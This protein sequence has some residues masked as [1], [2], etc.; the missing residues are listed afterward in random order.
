MEYLG[1]LLKALDLDLALT[2]YVVIGLF[3][4]ALT[5]RWERANPRVHRFL[6]ADLFIFTAIALFATNLAYSFY[7][8]E[9]DPL[10]SIAHPGIR[11]AYEILGI[12]GFDLHCANSM[13]PSWRVSRR[14]LVVLGFNTLFVLSIL[15]IELWMSP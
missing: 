1:I 10:N 13:W 2:S 4:F 9:A 8:H 12:V 14:L 11:L 15:A 6:Q 7:F 3:V 5:M